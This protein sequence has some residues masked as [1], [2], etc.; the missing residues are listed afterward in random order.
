M[1]SAVWLWLAW[2]PAQAQTCGPDGVL[3]TAGGRVF[4]VTGLAATVPEAALVSLTRRLVGG[5]AKL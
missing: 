4:S 3:R 1:L 5:M 2:A